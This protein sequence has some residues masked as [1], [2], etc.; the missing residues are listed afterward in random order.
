M[1]GSRM[2]EETAMNFCEVKNSS[3]V[4][5]MTDIKAVVADAEAYLD[6]SVGQT[7][8]A[9]AAAR[10]KLEKTLGAATAQVAETQRVLAEKTRAAARATD[11]YVHEKPWESIAMGAGVGLL[12]GLLISRR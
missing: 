7:G 3:R 1:I 10:K 2:T 5:L 12:L 4:K 6:A 11:T 9:Y 8:E